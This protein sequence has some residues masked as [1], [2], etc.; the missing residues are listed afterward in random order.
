MAP[1][2]QTGKA[3]KAEAVKGPPK[4]FP[5][6]PA[7]QLGG[8]VKYSE[9][10][11]RHTTFRIGGPAAI[12]FQPATAAFDY[13]R[14]LHASIAKIVSA[15]QAELVTPGHSQGTE[16]RAESHQYLQRSAVSSRYK[17]SIAFFESI[18]WRSIIMSLL[19]TS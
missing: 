1:R 13:S 2:K 6:F 18:Y 12:H 3:T 10:L 19:L 11:G 17:P 8:V 5:A 15:L 9:P 4:G 14:K 16:K 7:E